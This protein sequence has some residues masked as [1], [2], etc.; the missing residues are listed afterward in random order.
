[1]SEIKSK[2]AIRILEENQWKE[3]DPC[4]LYCVRKH[5]AEEAIITA[6][7]E[8]EQHHEQQLQELRDRAIE[9]FKSH[10]PNVGYGC[11]STIHSRYGFLCSDDCKK[12]RS[13]IEK[14]TEN[15]CQ[16]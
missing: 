11:K 16:Q 14:L 10:C 15:K 12:L 6:E 13:F 7:T 5:V 2:K 3:R 9:A 1:M 8:A 4:P